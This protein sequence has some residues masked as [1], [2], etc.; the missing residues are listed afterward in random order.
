MNENGHLYNYTEFLKKYAV[1]ITPNE[2]A[3]IFDAIPVE[4][5]MLLRGDSRPQLNVHFEANLMLDGINLTDKKCTNRHIRT[6]C[7]EITTPS[8][9]LL[10]NSKFIR[11]KL[12]LSVDFK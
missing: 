4:L 1:P 9:K 12:E 2:F 7:Q 8:A 6:F 3:I 11:Y 10:G 5:L